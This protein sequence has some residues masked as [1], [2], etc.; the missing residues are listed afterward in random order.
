M[1]TIKLYIVSGRLQ[2]GVT[3]YH[4]HSFSPAMKVVLGFW[5]TAT[6]SLLI[7]LGESIARAHTHAH[8]TQPP[9]HHSTPPHQGTI[10]AFFG[11]SQLFKLFSGKVVA[12][13][14]LLVHEKQHSTQR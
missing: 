12:V 3:L 7:T 9:M 10:F 2:D 6:F 4:L 5:L 14:K 11:Y 13:G 1:S 8:N